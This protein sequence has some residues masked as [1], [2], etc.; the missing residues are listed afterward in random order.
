VHREMINYCFSN[1]MGLAYDRGIPAE[2]ED[3][4]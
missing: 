3:A 1:G 4:A 2:G